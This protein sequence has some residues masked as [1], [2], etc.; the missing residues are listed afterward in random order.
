M[1]A[2]QAALSEGP[3]LPELAHEEVEASAAQKRFESRV[4]GFPW[5][6]VTNF[7]IGLICI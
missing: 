2:A 5:V 3:A 4:L 7:S 1:S 6:A